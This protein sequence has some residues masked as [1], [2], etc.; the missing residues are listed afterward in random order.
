MQLAVDP[1]NTATLYAA[2]E[3]L[4][5]LKSTSAGTS[6]LNV[7]GSPTFFYCIAVDPANS[8]ILLAGASA[9][10]LWESADHG[11][12]WSQVHWGFTSTGKIT[13]LSTLPDFSAEDPLP[14]PR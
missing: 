3:N 13:D 1:K 5:I 6:W 14:P 4:G 10:G 12:T 11:A 9:A 7:L 8:S 2:T